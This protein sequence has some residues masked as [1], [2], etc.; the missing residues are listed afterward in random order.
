MA[1]RSDDQLYTLPETSAASKAAKFKLDALL[2]EAHTIRHFEKRLKE[3][4]TEIS[5]IIQAQ[6]LAADGMLGVRS[7]QYCA[8]VRYQNGKRSLSKELLVENGVSPAVIAASEKQGDGYWL[9]ELPEIGAG[10]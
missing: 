6:G 2:K 4:K 1:K 10:D 9:V 7:G 3:I 5:E 8:I